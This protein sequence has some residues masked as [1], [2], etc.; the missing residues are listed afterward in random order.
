MSHHYGRHGPRAWL[1]RHKN[2]YRSSR[3]PVLARPVVADLTLTDPGVTIVRVHLP[4]NVERVIFIMIGNPNNDN[5]ENRQDLQIFT[6][7]PADI[8]PS[9]LPDTEKMLKVVS[10]D[11]P[12]VGIAEFQAIDDA[13]HIRDL[14]RAGK[15]V[16]IDWVK[17]G[18]R[19]SSLA[20]RDVRAYYQR[21]VQGTT[22]DYRR[23]LDVYR[24]TYL[25]QLNKEIGGAQERIRY[26][27]SPQEVHLREI[28]IQDRQAFSSY[29]DDLIRDLALI[30]VLTEFGIGVERAADRLQDLR[31][32][33]EKYQSYYINPKEEVLWPDQ[34]T[35][36][37]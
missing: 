19:A 2:R 7:Q 16:V 36:R 21:S 9:S 25:T 33:V 1:R 5:E 32:Y 34:E 10:S 18:D 12:I 22:D 26:L 28:A 6:N 27:A 24:T 4:A 15:F 17:V 20:R 30:R 31:P 29:K 8:V 11:N 23:S 14:H 3:L 37:S 35:F 13:E